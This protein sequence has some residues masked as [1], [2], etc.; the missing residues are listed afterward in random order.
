[1][2]N[3]TTQYDLIT[4]AKCKCCFVTTPKYRVPGKH[5]WLAWPDPISPS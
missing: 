2:V 4:K 5:G 1:M 3:K